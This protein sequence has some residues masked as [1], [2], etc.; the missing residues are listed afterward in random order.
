MKDINDRIKK[1]EQALR[2]IRTWAACFDSK[3]ETPCKAMDDIVSK[4]D[5]ALKDRAGEI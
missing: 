3:I 2:I 5:E 4:C 1:L